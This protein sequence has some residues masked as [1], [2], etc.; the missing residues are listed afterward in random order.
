MD[1][2]KIFEEIKRSKT[3]SQISDFTINRLIDNGCSKFKKEKDVIK[4]VK[5]ELHIVWGVFLK[6]ITNFDNLTREE[7]ITLH[8]S[9]DERKN[10]VEDF[11]KKIFESIQ[12]D[13]KNIADYGCGFNPLNIDHM[14]LPKDCTYFAY[15]IY[16]PEIEF[17]NKHLKKKIFKGVVRD[18][19]EEDSRQYDLVFLFKILPVLEEQKKGSTKEILQNLNTKYFAISFPLKSLSGKDVGMQTFYTQSFENILSEL[20]YTYEKIVFENELVYIVKKT[21]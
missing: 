4:Y 2:Q 7:L 13:I 15:D 21:N 1:K 14:D 11:Y 8:R 20:E 12:G 3:Y 10:F 18:I 6:K 17:L 19:F 16:E 9:T 5:K